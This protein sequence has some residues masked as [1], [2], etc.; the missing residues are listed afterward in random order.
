MYNT[1]C[2]FLLLIVFFFNFFCAFCVVLVFLYSF[3]SFKEIARTCVFHRTSALP[4]NS[5]VSIGR[6]ITFA[7][8]RH[9]T[10]TFLESFFQLGNPPSLG[11]KKTKSAFANMTL[12]S[13][14]QLFN[15][16]KRSSICFR[17][18]KF[19]FANNDYVQ[20]QWRENQASASLAKVCTLSKF[21]EFVVVWLN[22]VN[23]G[24]F[25]EGSK[26]KNWGRCVKIIFLPFIK[27]AFR[28]FDKQF[29]PEQPNC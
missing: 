27:K 26:T 16:I 14:F 19:D 6:Q 23:C 29:K 15:L 21:A 3:K 18:R 2:I 28:C 12:R 9:Y 8:Q 10:C 22:C 11:K 5:A 25:S 17:P 1:C 4:H 7:F 24:R 20:L 13:A